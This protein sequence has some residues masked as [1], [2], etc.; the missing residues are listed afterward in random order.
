MMKRMGS[1]SLRKLEMIALVKVYVK[2]RNDFGFVWSKVARIP[3]KDQITLYLS[4]KEAEKLRSIREQ[5]PR[6]CISD[7]SLLPE[8]DQ[9]GLQ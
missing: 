7:P 9:C 4:L 2:C 5:K 6:H 3:H 8:Q 1:D